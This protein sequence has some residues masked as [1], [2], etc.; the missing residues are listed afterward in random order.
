MANTGM[1]PLAAAA[2]FDPAL[3][4]SPGTLRALARKRIQP[5]RLPPDHPAVSLTT[6]PRGGR[7]NASR[8]ALFAAAAEGRPIILT[9]VRVPVAGERELGLQAALLKAIAA[10]FKRGEKAKAQTGP[11]GTRRRLAIA[12]LLR[13]WQSG[14]HVVS[15][16]DLH[17]RGTSLE[18]DI[19]T[20]ELSGFN[21]LPLGSED[22]QRQEMMTLVVSSRGNVTDSHSD[23]PDGSNHCF[24]GRKLWLAWETFEGQ[25]AGLEDCSRD[26]I[27][28]RAHFDLATFAGLR[29]AKWWTVGPGETLFLPGRLS[30]RVVTLDSYIGIGSFYCTPASCLENLSRWYQH[31]ALWELDDPK[32]ENAGLVDEI[33]LALAKKL[34][35]LAQQGP[36]LQHQWGMDF[37]GDGLRCW[38]RR[39]PQ[40][41]R[42][43]LMAQ[44]PPFAGLVN[45]VERLVSSGTARSAAR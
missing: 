23:D 33:T 6:T 26:A 45:G 27:H 39:W 12:E 14:R 7:P 35:R 19:D 22:M 9:N 37:L 11:N 21:L 20:T 36:R 10:G 38:Q 42:R 41:R 18:R 40:A 34:Q 28:Q 1:D 32:G 17:V 13:R 29:S 30:H 43:R 15:I 44:H 5:W 25:R 4:A 3:Q 16:T 24:V 31:G 8:E 2:A